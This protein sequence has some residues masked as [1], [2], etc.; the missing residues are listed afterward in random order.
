M[1]RERKQKEA[2]I[3]LKKFKYSCATLKNNLY[4][5]CTVNLFNG[6][7]IIA[8]HYPQIAFNTVHK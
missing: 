3:L 8:P 5:I 1:G 6:H 7:T 2:N 4:I